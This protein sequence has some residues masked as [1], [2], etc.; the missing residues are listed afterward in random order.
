ML[1][2]YNAPPI[3]TLLGS[4]RD[5]S[6]VIFHGGVES[7]NEHRNKKERALLQHSKDEAFRVRITSFFQEKGS[8]KRVTSFQLLQRYSALSI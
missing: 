4:R 3:N 2:H 5:A 6:Y 7:S 8:I 1:L